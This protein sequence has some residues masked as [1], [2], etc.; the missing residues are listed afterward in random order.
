MSLIADG[1]Q[2]QDVREGRDSDMGGLCMAHRSYVVISYEYME[3]P[4][5]LLSIECRIRFYPI[6]L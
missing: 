3:M 4:L 6:A 5:D 1:D 2:C